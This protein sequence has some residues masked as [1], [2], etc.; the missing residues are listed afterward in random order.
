MNNEEILENTLRV[1]FCI[2]S[3]R[4][5]LVDV[6]FHRVN[7]SL[8]LLDY[9]CTNYCKHNNCFYDIKRGSTIK[10]F[11]IYQSYKNQL[12]TYSKKHFD[13]FCRRDR[14]D[15]Q[16]MGSDGK[17]AS[18]QTTIGQLNFFRWCIYNHVYEYAATH[19]ES[20]EKEMNSSIQKRYQRREARD[21]KPTTGSFK[22]SFA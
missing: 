19:C 15:L 21:S 22:V 9:L 14:I 17:E 12:K 16:L 1:F 18:I 11:Y 6:L 4:N 20:I 5:I 8:R 10:R 2:P 3:H 13:P 7:I